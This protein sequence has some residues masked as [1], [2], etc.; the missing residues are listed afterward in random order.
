M[1]TVIM[2]WHNFPTFQFCAPS[3]PPKRCNKLSK[4]CLPYWVP[5]TAYR[6]WNSTLNPSCLAP[7]RMQTVNDLVG[8]KKELLPSQQRD[9]HSH[10]G[11]MSFTQRWTCQNCS[12][13]LGGKQRHRGL[14]LSRAFSP[15]LVL[16]H[17]CLHTQV[18]KNLLASHFKL[19]T[20]T[21]GHPKFAGSN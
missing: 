12:S 18:P 17:N 21:L 11:I 15:L 16:T 8:C 13:L 1:Q 7:R 19:W 3:R 6:Q 2:A 5:E 9:V 20:L 10:F 4:R 14:N